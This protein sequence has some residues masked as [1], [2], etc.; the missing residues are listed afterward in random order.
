MIDRLETTLK[1]YNTIEQELMNPEVLSN[2]NKT[3]ELSKEL[4]EIED[5]V[6]CYKKYKK[7]LN[8]I[9]EAT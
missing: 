2:V 8:N 1:R 6:N 4:S 9:E 7:V 3:R 5:L